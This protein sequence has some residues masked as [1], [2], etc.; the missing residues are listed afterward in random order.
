MLSDPYVD[1]QAAESG[2]GGELPAD[3]PATVEG[4]DLA[5]LENSLLQLAGAIVALHDTGHLHRDI[6]PSNIL[7]TPEGRVVVLD[8][9]ITALGHSALGWLSTAISVRFSTKRGRFRPWR[10]SW[11]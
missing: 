6:R 9:G 2:E 10:V 8:F 7:V 5:R 4:L 3:V 11:R 1:Q